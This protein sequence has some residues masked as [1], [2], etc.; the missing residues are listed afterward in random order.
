[1]PVRERLEVAL[2]AAEG[3]PDEA[4]AS[5]RNAYRE[6]KAQRL[7]DVAGDLV[8]SA[9]GRGAYAAIAPGTSVRWVVDQHAPA[10]SDGDVNA[11]AGPMAC[12]EAFPTG[13]RHPPAG[14]GCR[15]LLEPTHG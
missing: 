9:F 14:A 11:A 15:C 13:H 2:G 7:D 5:L 10:C 8:L 12:G 1:M 4:T 3:D 6:W